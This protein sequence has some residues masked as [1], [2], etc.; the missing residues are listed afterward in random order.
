MF[1]SH[2]LEDFGK[3]VKNL[4]QSLG[5]T[6]KEVHQNTGI[7]LETIR[8]LE[9]GERLIRFDNLTDLSLFYKIDLLEELRNYNSANKLLR[10]YDKLDDIIVSYDY[11][12]LMN[13]SN[14]F[15][16]YIGN[17]DENTLELFKLN[18]IN[19]FKQLI[20]G[21]TYLFS[22]EKSTNNLALDK[23]IESLQITIANFTL[24]NFANQR[25][26]VFE[27]R[28]LLIIGVTL[29]ETENHKKSNEI[30]QFIITKLNFDKRAVF[31]EK[32]LIIKTYFNISYNYNDLDNQEEALKYA[33]KGIEYCK[34]NEL[35]YN[36][37]HLYYRKGIAEHLLGKKEKIYMDSLHKAIQ[38]LEIQGRYELAKVYTNVTKDTYN[39]N[40]N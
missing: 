10:Y 12:K 40:I 27:M 9:K 39:I 28:I 25:Y 21:I 4:R 8:R 14:D 23:F 16:K 34:T 7:G 18:T 33:N 13:L 6:Q 1:E 35:I 3:R 5:Y 19:Q 15:E 20:K 30:L 36:L 29:N 37:N 17:D 24:D 26:N 32:K 2:N 22:G 31:N 11:Q 38:I